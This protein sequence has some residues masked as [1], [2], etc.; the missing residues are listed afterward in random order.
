MILI[1]SVISEQ[2]AA[3]LHTLCDFSLLVS[4]YRNSQPFAVDDV[5]IT[6]IF[7]VGYG[8]SFSETCRQPDG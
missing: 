2:T 4:F 5:E 3:I 1:L 6:E 8:K 7:Q